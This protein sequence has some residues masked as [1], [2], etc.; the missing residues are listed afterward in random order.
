MKQAFASEFGE[1]IHLKLK[2]VSP[3]PS[4]IQQSQIKGKQIPEF[5]ILSLLLPEKEE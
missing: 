1:D 3:E 4:E 2:I 5:K